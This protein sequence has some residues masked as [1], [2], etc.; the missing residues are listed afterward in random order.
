MVEIKKHLDNYLGFNSDLLFD[1]RR[2]DFVAI[3]GGALRDIVSGDEDTINDIDIIG[4]PQSLHYLSFVL[5]DNGYKKMNLVKPDLHIIYKDIKF[6]FEPITFMNSNNKIVQLIRPHN[7]NIKGMPPNEFQLLR[8]NYYALLTNVD[9]TSSGLFYDGEELYES[10]KFAYTHCKLKIYE[11]IHFAMMFNVDRTHIRAGRL[12][13]NKGWTEY[14]DNILLN[15]T[16]KIKQITNKTPK[17][18][19]DYINKMKPCLA[20]VRDQNRPLRNDK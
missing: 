1:K 17:Y 9:L 6:I 19:D 13:Y 7:T 5:E 12:K 10:I 18:I 8:Q 2:I 15:R 11:K 16:I 14:N 20:M 4:L 3:F